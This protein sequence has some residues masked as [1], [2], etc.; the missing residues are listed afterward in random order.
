MHCAIC[1]EQ[2]PSSLIF[3]TTKRCNH[4]FCRDCISW[5]IIVSTDSGVVN[6]RSVLG[7]ARCY[8][9][10]LNCGELIISGRGGG[11]GNV[12]RF[13]CPGCGQSG[14][15]L[16]ARPWVEGHRCNDHD[17]VNIHLLERLAERKQWKRC[18]NC[19]IYVERLGGCGDISCR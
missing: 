14:C 5:Y 17:A 12:G 11:N 2:V 9:P 18:P 15:F 10:N 8:C 3:R 4:S 7:F 19:N 1:L 13:K 16:C 6:V